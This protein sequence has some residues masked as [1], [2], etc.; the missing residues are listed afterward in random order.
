MGL[1]PLVWRRGFRQAEERSLLSL[2]AD[3]P[4]AA[5]SIH[6]FVRYGAQACGKHPG[7]WFG[8]F[9]TAKCIQ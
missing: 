4:K 3:N 9:A 5:F 8:P 1:T 2:F 7:E 6:N